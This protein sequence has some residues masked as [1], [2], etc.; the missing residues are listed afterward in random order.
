MAFEHPEAAPTALMT[1]RVLD[2]GYFA[3][4]GFIATPITE[5]RTLTFHCQNATPGP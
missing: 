4:G 2:R 3:A 5:H 1:A